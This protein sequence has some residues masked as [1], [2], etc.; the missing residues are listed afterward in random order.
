LTS[1]IDEILTVSYD[2]LTVYSEFEFNGHPVQ[3]DTI[4]GTAFIYGLRDGLTVS[5][6]THLMR[7]FNR[8]YPFGDTSDWIQDEKNLVGFGE[9]YFPSDNKAAITEYIQKLS[10]LRTAVINKAQIRYNTYHSLSYF[11]TTDIPENEYILP[12]D[13]LFWDINQMGAMD[14][15]QLTAMW[16]SF[17]DWV[18]RTAPDYD[19]TLD[20]SVYDF[21][22]TNADLVARMNLTKWNTEYDGNGDIISSTP[23]VL[24]TNRSI[25]IIPLEETLNLTVGNKDNLTQNVMMFDIGTYEFFTLT[26]FT[27]NRTWENVTDYQYDILG[28]TTDNIPVTSGEYIITTGGDWAETEFGITPDFAIAPVSVTATTYLMYAGIGM[29]AGVVV[30]GF[31]STNVKLEALKPVGLIILFGSFVAGA[32]IA[33]YYY[34]IPWATAWF[35]SVWPF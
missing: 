7:E 10:L 23:T 33:V 4:A 22:F 14:V 24:F 35:S 20:I 21:N 32:G 15:D 16:F 6:S 29:V 2:P 3:V 28:L 26:V 11:N 27:G 8:E 25:I 31:S 1:G 5:P 19:T 13:V 34:V 12:V 18:N 30:W 9:K 17:L